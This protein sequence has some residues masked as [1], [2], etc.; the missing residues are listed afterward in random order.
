MKRLL[1]KLT[2]YH[3]I[4]DKKINISPIIYAKTLDEIFI[5][6]DLMSKT[7]HFQWYEVH[8]V[9]VGGLE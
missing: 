3:N 1:W 7:T 2:A 8:R 5:I 9:S 4:N 6:I